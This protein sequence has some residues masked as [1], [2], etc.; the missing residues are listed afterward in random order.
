[1]SSDQIWSIAFVV[2]ILLVIGFVFE[3]IESTWDSKIKPNLPQEKTKA[4]LERIDELLNQGNIVAEWIGA[5]A[6]HSPSLQ[7]QR[8]ISEMFEVNSYIEDLEEVE[9]QDKV[10]TDLLHLY[11][12]TLT[13]RYYFARKEGLDVDSTVAPESDIA[14]LSSLSNEELYIKYKRAIRE[15]HRIHED[16]L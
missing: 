8:A 7:M 2:G 9:N 3:M 11:K 1:M 12:H 15:I 4:R 13:V 14:K 10:F 16:Y 5:N 6:T